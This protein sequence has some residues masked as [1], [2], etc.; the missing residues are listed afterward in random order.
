M[1]W[2]GS[3]AIQSPSSTP[4]DAS[5]PRGVPPRRSLVDDRAK[6]L[7]RFPTIDDSVRPF[8]RGARARN[9]A[10]CLSRERLPPADRGGG[11]KGRPPLQRGLSLRG[12]AS[13]VIFMEAPRRT[14]GRGCLP[15]AAAFFPP[16]HRQA[17][18]SMPL[19]SG[20]TVRAIASPSLDGHRSRLVNR[21][22][23]RL[24]RHGFA[25]VMEDTIDSS[26]RELKGSAGR[27]PGPVD[28][29]L[30][31][32]D[33]LAKHTITLQFAAFRAPLA[34]SGSGS[35]S[36]TGTAFGAEGSGRGFPGRRGMV[37]SSIYFTYQFYT[38]L[39]TRTERMV[40][41]PDGPRDRLYEVSSSS[42][43]PT[44]TP[45]LPRGHERGFPSRAAGREG[46]LGCI[47]VAS[48]VLTGLL[49]RIAD[50]YQWP[51]MISS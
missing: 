13:G 28:I 21:T 40:L 51:R 18:M 20:Y 16:P 22:G 15:A 4:M 32:A 35:G 26:A 25:D 24:S 38:C 2:P 7:A 12:L 5:L 49:R 31:A 3:A 39:P 33:P 9:A 43:I 23:C 11:G 36:V 50:R 10:S 45:L 30:E 48:P 19:S 37:P 29:D 44:P 47:L 6:K 14:A 17:D 41:R 27:H 1:P 34:S 42:P 8:S 46:C